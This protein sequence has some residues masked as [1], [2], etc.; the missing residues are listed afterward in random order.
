MADKKAQVWV[1]TVIYTLIG[2]SVIAVILTVVTPQI[3]KIKDR[4]VIQQTE[5]AMTNL[6]QAISSVGEYAAGS[7]KYVNLKISKG[8]L[9]IDGQNDVIR[10]VLDNT[11]LELSQ[12]GTDIKDGDI[13]IRT[14]QRGS[15]FRITLTLNYS[16]KMN[17]TYQNKEDLK[18]LSPS[19]VEYKIS[20]ENVGD[21]AVS[22]N[23]HINFGV[24]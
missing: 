16:S 20:L 14:D 1:E 4:G 11:V 21:N 12:N 17:L 22:E 7:I 10:Y 2:L 6:D 8:S 18:T 13:T 19:S 3:E 23:P 24:G 15:K 9:Q 5:A